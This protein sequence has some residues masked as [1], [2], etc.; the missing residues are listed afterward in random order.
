MLLPGVGINVI[1]SIYSQRTEHGSGSGSGGSVRADLTT[2]RYQ[3]GHCEL[4]DSDSLSGPRPL[5]PRLL[6]RHRL[7]RR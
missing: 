5:S 1:S 3:H 6:L 4:S 2:A 7:R